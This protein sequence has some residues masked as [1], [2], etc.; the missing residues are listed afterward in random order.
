MMMISNSPTPMGPAHTVGSGN[1]RVMDELASFAKMISLP[2]GI[3]KP[4]CA[5][6]GRMYRPNNEGCP[7]A[8]LKGG[9]PEYWKRLDE[10]TSVDSPMMTDVS[11]GPS[12]PQRTVNNKK[13]HLNARS[14]N[15]DHGKIS[16]SKAKAKSKQTPV[17]LPL[18]TLQ[19]NE[20][21]KPPYSFPCLIGLA[22]QSVP[23]E[24]MSVAQIYEYVC[25]HFPYFRT[26]KPGWKNSVRHNLSLNK[27]FCK[28]ERRQN[29]QGK[30][31][32]WGI[33]QKTKE[34]LNRDIAACQSRFPSKFVSNQGSSTIR[35]QQPIMPSAPAPKGV[36]RAH[37]T[38]MIF[39]GANEMEPQPEPEQRR[40]SLPAQI[41]E[42]VADYDFFGDSNDFGITD[43]F[44]I[45]GGTEM[46]GGSEISWIHDSDSSSPCTTDDMDVADGWLPIPE[47]LSVFIDDNSHWQFD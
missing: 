4:L 41:P 37:S 1:Q 43:N 26:A 2:P 8:G 25:H 21:E 17:Q 39:T 30:G 42:F 19:A 9:S 38:P 16:Q 10:A 5:D 44:L 15:A 6:S 13:N 46:G 31:N 45:G 11:W 32:M 34:Q 36:H 27:F 12:S 18:A 28:L 20:H 14:T 40:V 47:D 7:T 23:D 29:E 22:L 3:S 24:R 33:V 35:G